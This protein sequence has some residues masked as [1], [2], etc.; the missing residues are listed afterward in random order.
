[1][2]EDKIIMQA[3]ESSHIRYIG[4]DKSTLYVAFKIKGS[5]DVT[6]Y[7]YENVRESQYKLLMQSDSKGTMFAAFFKGSFVYSALDVS[8]PTQSRLKYVEGEVDG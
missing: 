1:M 4:F 6:V 7:L 3:V 8:S 5:E 2:N